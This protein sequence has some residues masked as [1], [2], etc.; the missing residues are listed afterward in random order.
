MNNVKFGENFE[1]IFARHYARNLNLFNQIHIMY[2][3]EIIILF[4]YIR[5]LRFEVIEAV[6]NK[7]IN[8]VNAIKK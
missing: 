7:S 3:I 4:L 5:S 6:K 1:A 8:H 2:K